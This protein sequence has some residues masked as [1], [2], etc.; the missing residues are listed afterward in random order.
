MLRRSTGTPFRGSQWPK[1]Q[2]FEQEN[3]VL[4]NYILKY[5]VTIHE[6]ILT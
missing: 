6:S 4:L 2:Q 1:L 5:K 3:K